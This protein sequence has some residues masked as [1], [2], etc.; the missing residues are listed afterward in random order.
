MT[1]LIL[2]IRNV[3]NHAS[4]TS[5]LT[6]LH[7]A[8]AASAAMMPSE[9]DSFTLFPSSSSLDEDALP[10]PKRDNLLDFNRKKSDDE[11][12]VSGNDSATWEK[13]DEQ[14]RYVILAQAEA[15]GMQM[16]SQKTMTQ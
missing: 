7:A 6:T 9:L 11:L 16:I 2:H 10:P 13:E 15:K 5:L 14:M 4:A 12:V 1:T 3:E 8:S